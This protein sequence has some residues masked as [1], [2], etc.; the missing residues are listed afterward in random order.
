MVSELE[1]MFNAVLFYVILN[2]N[3]ML[4]NIKNIMYFVIDFV[5]GFFE[6]TSNNFRRN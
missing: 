3:E 1:N 4:I 5:L 2:V 6:F